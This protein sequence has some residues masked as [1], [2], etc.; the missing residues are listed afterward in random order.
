IR[1]TRVLIVGR[2]IFDS[3]ND[4]YQRA[5]TPYYEVRTFDPFSS[6]G[7]L[8]KSLGPMWGT[9]LNQAAQYLSRAVVREP[10]ALA[11]L[12]VGRVAREFAPDLVLVSCIESLRPQT[13]A[14]LRGGNPQCRVMG[15]FSD[16]LANFGRGYFMA[17]DYDALF[18][19]DR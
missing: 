15:V 14:A 1:L 18:F 13:V 4:S 10:L 3:V 6:F 17:A 8:E 2:C 5:L 12:R 11:E 7:A 16:H 19:K 9:R